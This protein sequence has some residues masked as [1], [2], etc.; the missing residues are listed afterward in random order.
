MLRLVNTSAPA[1]ASVD[2]GDPTATPIDPLA[3]LAAA[4]AGGD[5]AA[6]RSLLVAVGPIILRA[7]RGVLGVRHPDVED[8]AQ[9][10][11]ISVLR[12]L[13]G[14]RAECSVAHF[15]GRIAAFTAMAAR[16]RLRVRARF[17]EDAPDAGEEAVS[18]GATP[19]SAAAAARCRAVLRGLLDELPAV[20]AEALV[21]QA[22][23]GYSLE[24]IA[25]STVVPVNT[26]RSRLRLAKAALRDALASS[27][28]LAEALEVLV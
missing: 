9:D 4:A 15:V 11:A 2:D 27:P 6:Q 22:V 7:A 5:A 3:P 13:P 8:A 24:E 21:L 19:A 23:M 25:V 1:P 28:D 14:F 16:R 10:A 20:Q 12:A 17:T 26:A 18:P